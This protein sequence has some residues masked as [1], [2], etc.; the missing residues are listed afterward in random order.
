LHD[1]GTVLHRRKVSVVSPQLARCA[2]R[3]PVKKKLCRL[4][5][6]FAKGFAAGAGGRSCCV[7]ICAERL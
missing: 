4:M 7:A 3:D 6:A 2:A 1:S 5:R